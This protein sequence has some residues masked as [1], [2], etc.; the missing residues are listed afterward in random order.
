MQRSADSISKTATIRTVV[1]TGRCGLSGDGGPAVSACLNE[2][3]GIA[4]DGAG[5]LLIADSENH[6]I[7]KV[8]VTGGTIST[9]GGR[10]GG[11]DPRRDVLRPVSDFPTKHDDP[12]AEEADRDQNRFLQ[13][14]TSVG[15]SGM[16]MRMALL[17]LRGDGGPA[18][19]AL[20]NFPTAV[21]VDQAGICTGR[22]HEPS[23]SSHRYGDRSNQHRGWHRPATF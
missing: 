14:E 9:I 18:S 21:A 1:G 4:L 3:K 8:D 23:S 12:L 16:S 17:A 2:P 5:N 20:F 19:G 11:A 15:R 22:T 7:R 13:Q 10:E 6:V